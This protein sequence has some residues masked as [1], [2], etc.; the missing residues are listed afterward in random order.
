M[1][2]DE[3]GRATPPGGLREVFLQRHGKSPE[4][5]ETTEITGDTV[6]RS[7]VRGRGTR[8]LSRPRV[9]SQ[10][11]AVGEQDS[12]GRFD[13]KA[14]LEHDRALIEQ[15]TQ[16][17]PRRERSAVGKPPPPPRIASS[18]A[19]AGAHQS[20]S[21]PALVAAAVGALGV[22]NN[23][24]LVVDPRLESVGPT[25]LGSPL[26]QEGKSRPAG[27]AVE[28]EVAL[29]AGTF[30]AEATD[31]VD[32]S[33]A[34]PAAPPIEPI[35]P[36]V[37]GLFTAR[38]IDSLM[39]RLGGDKRVPAGDRSQVVS[40]APAS[41]SR[42]MP[43][44][45]SCIQNSGDISKD[46]FRSHGMD[47]PSSAPATATGPRQHENAADRSCASA[48][49]SAG[50]GGR[51]SRRNEIE[52][53]D[54]W[55]EDTFGGQEQQE[56]QFQRTGPVGSKR[57]ETPPAVRASTPVAI[58]ISNNVASTSATIFQKLEKVKR[59]KKLGDR[60]SPV[61]LRDLA[62]QA[63]PLFPNM[64]LESLINMLR[65]FTSARFEDHDLYLRI[66]GEIPVQVRGITPDLLTTCMRVLQRLRLPEETYLELFSMEAMNMIRARRRAPVRTP[67]RPPAVQSKVDGDSAATPKGLRPTTPP[68][69][70]P[71]EAPSPF[72]AEQLIHIGNALTALGANPSARFLDIFQSQFG[73]AIARMTFQE[74]ELVSPA[75]ATSQFMPDSLRRAF[76]VRC[77][78]VDAGQPLPLDED[79]AMPD[80][81]DYQRIVAV[82]QRRKKHHIN[83]F[84]VESSIR[85]ETFSFFTSLPPEVRSYLDRLHERAGSLPPDAPSTLALQVASVLEQ[86]GVVCEV[87]RR[88]GPLCLHVVAK[89][90]NPHKD[91]AD[92]IYECNDAQAFYIARQDDKGATPRPTAHTRFRHRLLQRLRLQLIHI[93][94]WE[95]QVM[96]DAQ[97]INYMVKLQSL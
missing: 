50:R 89:A 84:L 2:R 80:I 60:P 38:D 12:A 88:S 32:E 83:I 86:L 29:Q 30:P 70:P 37:G 52:A 22:V 72:R 49:A 56:T 65:L 4:A 8:S 35:V 81:A 26:S 95:W 10:S 19:H 76:L 59:E 94:I 17:Q 3:H 78:E 62:A 92:V 42:A 20:P 36:Q 96:G 54:S 85:K 34:S 46:F 47:V 24:C 9:P 21:P 16:R 91:A 71:P 48:G 90:T 67:R 82:R 39:D 45:M 75:L 64:A 18:R 79:A 66:L 25:L 55:M 11:P 63:K 31:V 61:L 68:T 23:T 33:D 1:A 87:N 97:R 58:D 13:Q 93:N 28:V 40:S 15:L 73:L 5:S 41:S 69:P 77:A 14:V 74:C 43:D 44:R 27:A 53:I 7:R 57:P 51:R 6:H